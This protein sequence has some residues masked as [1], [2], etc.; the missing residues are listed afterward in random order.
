[1]LNMQIQRS[2]PTVSLEHTDWNISNPI[3]HLLISGNNS[4]DITADI[5]IVSL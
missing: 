1:M 5:E 4:V 3:L 2:K